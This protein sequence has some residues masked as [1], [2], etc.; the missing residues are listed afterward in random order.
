[1]SQ[2]SDLL[3]ETRI[4][5]ESVADFLAGGRLR[6][7]VTGLSRAGKT[8]FIT[9]LVHHLTRAIAARP[10]KGGESK[11]Q[12]PVF[13]ALA[14]GRI[15]SA[16]LDP[17]P[18][19]SVPRFAYEEH[20]AA[21]TGL[22]RHW[23]QSTRRISELRVTLEYRSKGWSLRKG[24]GQGPTRLDID[25]VDYPGEWLLDL[26]LLGKSYAQ[27]SHETLDAASASARAMIASEWR[28]LTAQTDVKA[29]YDE[30]TAQ[31]LAQAFT[32]Y[33]RLARSERFALSSLPPGRFLM[34]G[35]LEGSPALTFAPLPVSESEELPYRSLGREMERRYEAYK[36]QVVRPFFRDHFARLDRQIVLVDA[37]AALNSG[38]E[39]V[40]DLETALT[41][42]LTAFRTGRANLF[43]TIFRPKID[44]IL[45]A[46][47]KADHLHHTSHD[48]LEA[49]LRHLTARAIERAEG[50]GAS[51]DVIALAAVRATRE[52]MVRH[53]GEK[54][55]AIVGTPVA[56]ERIGHETFDG[57][58]EGAIFPGELPADPRDVFKG[59]ALAVSDEE[60]D[61]RFLKFRPPAV[62]LGA[63][64]KPLPLPHIRLDRAMEF[65][66]GDRLS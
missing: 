13:R 40:R 5:T 15:T 50:V 56:G 8:V 48:R 34:P 43:S 33:L 60:A 41:G 28:G 57:V 10:E 27:W 6:L 51:I 59:E 3:F 12:L 31:K 58:A 66:F 16:H 46:A 1:M 62:M 37:L 19:Y 2:L 29:R 25:I 47:T 45:F 65:L 4:A 7:G 9:A 18:D 22:D 23:P 30:E 21:L 61:F 24:F 11:T 39:A 20:L 14:E 36:S 35:D 42:V 44:R 55:S 38:P 32:Q 26:P 54:L 17:Q 63:D 64:Q 49:I 53:E 52:A